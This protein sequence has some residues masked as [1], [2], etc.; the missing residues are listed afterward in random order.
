MLNELKKNELIYRDIII[1]S[2]TM[3]YKRLKMHVSFYKEGLYEV[4]RDSCAWQ[5]NSVLLFIVCEYIRDRAFIALYRRITACVTDS[6]C[7]DQVS[8][9]VDN[10]RLWVTVSY[11]TLDV[12]LFDGT[13]IWKFGNISP[14]IKVAKLF[15]HFS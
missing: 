14:A 10:A 5:L 9:R 7:D 12:A 15:G 1:N 13:S 6:L 2:K 8:R 3:N 11:K 4:K